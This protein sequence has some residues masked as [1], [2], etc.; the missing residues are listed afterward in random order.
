MKISIGLCLCVLL[1][2]AVGIATPA[3]PL[4]ACLENSDSYPWLLQ[5]GDGVVQY[6]LNK[7]AERLGIELVMTPLPWKRCLS[8]VS[9]GQMDAAIKMSY[10]AERAKTVGVY[11]MRNGQPDPNKRLLT[12][13]YSLYQLKGGASH[14]DGAQLSVNGVVAAQSGFSIVEF[15]QAAGANV[16]D[17]SREPLIIL[18]KLVMNRAAAAALQTEVADSTL[19]AHPELQVRLARVTPV[20]V[21]KPY[22]LVFSH[23]FYQAHPEECQQ[24]WDAIE[25]VRRSVD[26]R[27]YAASLRQLHPAVSQ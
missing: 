4:R 18:K 10:S 23:A 9:Q 7:V 21:E 8:L 25:Q 13:S 24:V 14:W 15:L 12:E 16:D 27:R 2:P 11:P 5:S 1:F 26:Y 3:F 20:L 22:Y 17:S 6:Q 19:A